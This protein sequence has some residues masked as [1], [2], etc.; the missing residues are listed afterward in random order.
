MA[1]ES[2][3]P[4]GPGLLPQEDVKDKG[5][6]RGDNG[7]E[8]P[9]LVPGRTVLFSEIE[10]LVGKHQIEEDNGF[11]SLNRLQDRRDQN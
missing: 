10:K 7:F 6:Q 4:H 8:N 5:G 9:T 11:L 1:A 3:S 2:N